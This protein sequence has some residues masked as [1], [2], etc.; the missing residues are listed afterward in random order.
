[1]LS[2]SRK[3]HKSTGASREPPLT[4]SSSSARFA[5]VGTFLGRVK[6]RDVDDARRNPRLNVAQKYSR[7]TDPIGGT[8]GTPEIPIAGLQRDTR[9]KEGTGGLE[10]SGRGV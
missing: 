1:M 8:Y 10:R 2:V 7:D 3:P 5:S 9:G 6:S 4:L